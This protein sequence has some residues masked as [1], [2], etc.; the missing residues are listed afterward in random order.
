MAS[1]HLGSAKINSGKIDLPENV[2]DFLFCLEGEL[3]EFVEKDGEIVVRRSSG[4]KGDSI[5]R[6]GAIVQ[7]NG[8]LEAGLEGLIEIAIEKSMEEVGLNPNSHID[9]FIDVLVQHLVFDLLA[10]FNRQPNKE[11]PL[12]FSNLLQNVMSG[13]TG[14]DPS[15]FAENFDLSKMLDMF[16]PFQGSGSSNPHTKV[17]L[18]DIEDVDLDLEVDQEAPDSSSQKRY[19]IPIDDD[20]EEDSA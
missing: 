2:M 10:F 7:P 6:E 9:E 14:G 12:D 19:R 5:P 18:E 3:L 17:V 15:K 16:S 20:E 4:G 8:E 11:A 13:L 1:K